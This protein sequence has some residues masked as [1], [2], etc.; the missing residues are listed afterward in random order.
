MDR[1]FTINTQAG[2]S[3]ILRR[4]PKWVLREL[5]AAYREAYCDKIG[6]QFMHI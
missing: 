3:S 5:L 1:E 2:G 4:K 6:V